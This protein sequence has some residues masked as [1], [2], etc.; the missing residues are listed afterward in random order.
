MKTSICDLLNIKYPIIQGAM[1]WIATPELVSAVS[2]AGGLGIIGSGAAPSEE[3]RKWI[4]RTKEMTNKP[5]GVNIMLMAPNAS[6]VAQIIV[7]E[8]VPVVT[9]GAGSPGPF[10]PS[11]KE[12]G[13]KV[14]PVIPSVALG[15]RLERMGASAVVAEGMEAG[16]HVGETGTLPLIPQVVDA[17]K[18][19]VIA[20]GGFCDGRGLV[21]ALALGAQGIQ[22]GTRFICSDECIAHANFKQKIIE[23]NDRATVVTGRELGH[24]A[25]CLE[26]RMTQQLQAMI[27]NGVSPEELEMVLAGSLKK[28]TIDGD[29]ENG[30]MM[31][32]QISGMIKDIKPV[33]KI[34]DD[35]IAEAQAILS[36]LPSTFL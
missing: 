28:A 18:I 34:I 19:P 30:S 15:K 35:I 8:N 21:A 11:F 31:A 5:F 12:K 23:A 9:T 4:R 16:G 1:A 27:K 7:E 17:L 26:N 36:S 20:S 29:V 10:I 6:S 3:V 32:G 22:M 14:I 13:I 24:P 25:R 33:K 2:N